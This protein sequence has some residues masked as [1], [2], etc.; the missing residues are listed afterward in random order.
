[1]SNEYGLIFTV[2]NG[3]PIRP[4]NLLRNFKSLLRNSGL[5]PIRF[6]DLR[7]TVASLMLNH[8]IPLI[9]ASRRLGHARPSITLDVYGHL[10]PTMQN[11]VAQ[12]MDDLISPIEIL[13]VAPGC[14]W[15]EI[16]K[17]LV[18][19]YTPTHGGKEKKS[20]RP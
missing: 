12:L 19:T 4:R 16:E 9:I 5:P 15:N 8:G 13:Q 6:H 14:T 1:M 2:S 7:H 3:K 11:E 10:N 17:N 20:P 18:G